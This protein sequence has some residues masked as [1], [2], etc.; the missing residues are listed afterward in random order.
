MNYKI[1]VTPTESKKLQETLF[2][3]SKVC[4]E[5][6][7]NSL[8]NV[9]YTHAPYLFIIDNTLMYGSAERSF[10]VQPQEEISAQALIF[11][12]NLKEY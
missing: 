12:L 11:I 3:T 10:D 1:K 5:G 7:G 4:W 6:G 9:T 2:K 8:Q